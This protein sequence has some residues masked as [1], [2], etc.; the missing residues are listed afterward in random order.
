[1]ALKHHVTL[2]TVLL[3]AM[4]MA[5]A[6]FHQRVH[7]GRFKHRRDIEITLDSY[8]GG[9][10]VRSPWIQ[11]EWLDLAMQLVTI[12]QSQNQPG[13]NWIILEFRHSITVHNPKIYT[14]WSDLARHVVRIAHYQNLQVVIEIP[15]DLEESYLCSANRHILFNRLKHTGKEN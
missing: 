14:E 10:A 12:G 7:T 2:Y 1:M 4:P 5:T 15:Q 3:L 6:L 13:D 11:V 8:H 9:F